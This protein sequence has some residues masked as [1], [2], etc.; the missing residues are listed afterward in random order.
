M[1]YLEILFQYTQSHILS[2]KGDYRTEK[3]WKRVV[4]RNPQGHFSNQQSKFQPFGP[5]GSLG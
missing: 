1:G 4:G 3:I 5:E 2:T